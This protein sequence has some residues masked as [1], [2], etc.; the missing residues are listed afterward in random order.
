MSITKQFVLL[1]ILAECLQRRALRS[2]DD[3]DGLVDIASW[4]EYKTVECPIAKECMFM[5]GNTHSH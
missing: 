2:I 4:K 5:G 1:G 3:V